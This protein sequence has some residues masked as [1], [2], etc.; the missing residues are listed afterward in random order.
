MSIISQTKTYGD[1]SIHQRP[2]QNRP[3]G[4]SRQIRSIYRIFRLFHADCGK[5]STGLLERSSS[6][7]NLSSQVSQLKLPTTLSK[8]LDTTHAKQG[9]V[10][11]L[12]SSFGSQNSSSYL[13]AR[14]CR[15]NGL[16]PDIR[17]ARW[18]GWA[19]YGATRWRP[20]YTSLG[21]VWNHVKA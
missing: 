19:L 16:V 20:N 9:T 3:D 5:I 11:P 18:V 17:C 12:L 8:T 14:A 2:Q 6:N 10:I 7:I 4:R 15:D 1:T 13:G 21:L